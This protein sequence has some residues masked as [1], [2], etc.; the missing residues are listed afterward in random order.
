M[1]VED[2]LHL[3]LL[4]LIY[5]AHVALDTDWGLTTLFSLILRCLS[6]FFLAILLV[7]V[8]SVM[9]VV[10]AVLRARTRGRCTVLGHLVQL[11]LGVAIF[12]TVVLEHTTRCIDDALRRHLIGL[13]WL[14][15]LLLLL[16]V[17]HTCYRLC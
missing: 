12:L 11:I 16:L 9:I 4:F 8:I 17:R 13:L 7:L 14:L 2:D 6:F 15:H 10:I 5:A 1:I 3:E